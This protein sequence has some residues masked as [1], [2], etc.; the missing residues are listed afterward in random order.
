MINKKMEMLS[1]IVLAPWIQKATALRCK[2]RK[3][4]GNQFRHAMATMSILID[5]EFIDPIL[6]K[7]S[8]IHDLFED[9]PE[10]ANESELRK[11]DGDG[12]QVVDLVF[13]VT[14]REGEE[15]SVFLNR[16]LTT[17][18]PKA[19]ILKIADRISNLTDLH[20]DV[21]I[22]E[23][24]EKYLEDTEKYVIPMA[25]AVDNKNFIHELT[26]LVEIRKLFIKEFKA[27]VSLRNVVK[28]KLGFH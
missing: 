5:Y 4:G 7:A 1:G 24:M 18:T 12:N 15:K 25:I 16:I 26:D 10:A 14:K 21:I 6:L 8:V 27:N 17:G 28:K 11:L 9:Y 22:E 13:E 19:K 2:K 3:T 23:K 20:L